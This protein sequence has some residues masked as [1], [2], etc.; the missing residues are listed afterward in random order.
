MLNDDTLVQLTDEREEL[1]AR[2]ES[3]YDALT[4]VYSVAKRGKLPEGDPR[5]A[6]ARVM[7]IIA[8]T[9]NA[10]DDLLN[11][12]LMKGLHYEL[13]DEEAMEWY[14]AVERQFHLLNPEGKRRFVSARKRE[15]A[16][17]ARTDAAGESQKAG[18][19]AGTGGAPSILTLHR[20]TE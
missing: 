18:T 5:E 15:A 6:L 19:L 14:E 9:K 7:E 2:S 11:A 17:Q 8:S 10:L 20:D 1:I 4:H 12:G 13:L 16:R 3:L